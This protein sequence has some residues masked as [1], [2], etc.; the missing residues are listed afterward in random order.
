[1][2]FSLLKSSMTF[3]FLTFPINGGYLVYSGGSVSIS[4]CLIS[5]K[6]TNS[7]TLT[8]YSFGY[9]VRLCGKYFILSLKSL[10]LGIGKLSMLNGS[11]EIDTL[12][13]TVHCTL[14]L[15]YP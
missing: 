3:L 8:V 11:N 9:S 5:L 13:H 2:N 1:M 10:L 7:P 4:F 14:D 6:V 12:L 15:S